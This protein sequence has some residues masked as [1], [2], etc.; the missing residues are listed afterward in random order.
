M[1]NE[2]DVRIGMEL[3]DEVEAKA[4]QKLGDRI[5]M[6]FGVEYNAEFDVFAREMIKQCDL[7]EKKFGD[8]QAGLAR[9]SF[10]KGRLYGVYYQHGPMAYRGGHKKAVTAYER[11]IQLGFDEAIVRYHLGVV[12]SVGLSKENAI[13][14]FKRV[15]E[16][17]G[18]NSE[19]GIQ[20]GME[21]EK[22]KVKKGGC[23]IA[24]AAYGS[25][26][27]SEVAA[28]SRFRDDTL[29]KSKLGSR[30]VDLYYILSP[31]LASLISRSGFLKRTIR[32]LVLAP[33]LKALISRNSRS[34]GHRRRLL[35]GQ[36]S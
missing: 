7:A 8:F 12:Y 31:P 35:T 26:L 32:T 22:L 34:G 25:P 24:T 33:I 19:L 16:L 1:A 9:A 5:A 23:F 20:S 18:P 29:L 27:S 2:A 30:F 14:N 13:Q 15:I 3:L 6:P 36:N 21:I 10:L 28:L 11:A 4:G 17:Q